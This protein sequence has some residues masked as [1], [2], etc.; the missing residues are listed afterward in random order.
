MLWSR[1]HRLLEELG[2]HLGYLQ[3]ANASSVNVEGVHNR[4]LI[5][6][7]TLCSV[8]CPL[9]MTTHQSGWVLD[10]Y[11]PRSCPHCFTGAHG[12]SAKK[13]ESNVCLCHRG[14][15]AD[16]HPT[17]SHYRGGMS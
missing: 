3:V 5:A 11:C 12:L 10:H 9:K 14:K 7:V 8:S 16:E 2:I 1:F 17:L 6:S 15:V 13:A 4:F